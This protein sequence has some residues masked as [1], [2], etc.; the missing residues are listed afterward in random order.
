M[1]VTIWWIEGVDIATV[2][3]MMMQYWE[4]GGINRTRQWGLERNSTQEKT[5]AKTP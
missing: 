1:E 5:Q 3:A 2:E 4:E